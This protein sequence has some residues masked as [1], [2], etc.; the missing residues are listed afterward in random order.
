MTE[1]TVD[2]D[3]AQH[4]GFGIAGS[5]GGLRRLNGVDMLPWI[6]GGLHTSP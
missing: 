6:Y 2:P 4:D 1:V 3:H 5:W